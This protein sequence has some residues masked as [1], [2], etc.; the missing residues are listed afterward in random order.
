MEAWEWLKG[1]HTSH[2]FASLC[3]SPE[4][5]LFAD[6]AAQGDAAA[7]GQSLR[8]GLALP[9]WLHTQNSAWQFEHLL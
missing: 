3:N 7:L 9:G 2:R 1:L 6:F 5:L 4:R 8:E